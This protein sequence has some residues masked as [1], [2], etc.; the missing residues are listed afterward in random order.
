F[1]WPNLM[2]DIKWYLRTCN[3]CQQQQMRHIVILPMV[4]TLQPLFFQAHCDMMFMPPSKR[5]RYILQAQCLLM[6]WLGD[7][8]C[9]KETAKVIEDF[10][11]KNILCCWGAIS[12]IVMD[13]G[14]PWISAMNAL[15]EKYHL[16]HI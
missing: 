14:S 3:E 12:K 1:F 16:N 2:E 5:M 8:I 9:Q 6:H 11:H 4:Q 7:M 15:K 10:I 13:N